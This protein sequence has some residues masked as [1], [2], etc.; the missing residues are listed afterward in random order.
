MINQHKNVSLIFFFSINTNLGSGFF[1]PYRALVV[2]QTCS[3][4]L[5]ITMCLRTIDFSKQNHFDGPNGMNAVVTHNSLNQIK[6]MPRCGQ[7]WSSLLP[8]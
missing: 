8:F 7:N 4:M 3:N 2:V 1:L 5:N 6:I